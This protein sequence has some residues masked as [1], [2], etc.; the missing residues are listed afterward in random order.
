MQL[1]KICFLLFINVLFAILTVNVGYSQ[2]IDKAAEKLEKYRQEN[3]P[4]ERSYSRIS[5][6]YALQQKFRQHAQYCG[7]E[8][9][10]D[11]RRDYVPS[12]ISKFLG[13]RD[14]RTKVETADIRGGGLMY[15]IFHESELSQ[16]FNV[17][18]YSPT[19]II[20]LNGITDQ[21]ALNPEENF[22]TYIL[23][24]TCGGYLKAALDAGIEPPYAA[25]RAALE[26]DSRRESSILALSGSFVSP[27]KLALDANDDATTEAMMKLWKFYAENPKYVNQ[28]YYLREFEGVLIRHISSAEENRKIEMEG[29]LDLSGLLPARLKTSFGVGA[30][31]QG[32]F[33]GTDWETIIYADY[34]EKGATRAQLFSKLPSPEFIRRYF[35]NVRPA[36]QKSRDFPVMTEGVEHKHFV[37]VEGIPEGMS[38]NFWEIESVKPGVYDG[39][40]TLQAEYFNDSKE[41]SSGC[42]FTITGKPLR[43]NFEGSEATRPSRLPLQYVIRSKNPVGGEYIRF[44]VNEE[45]QTSAHPIASIGAGEFDLTKKE[46]RKFAFQWQFEVDIEDSYNPVDFAETPYIGNLTV[47]RSDKNINVRLAGI[48]HD[49]QRRKFIIT[50][51]TFDT[52]ALEKIDDVNM[53]A[54]NLSLDMYL[55]SKISGSNSVRPL[56]G[57][58]YFPSIK[59]DSP[60]EEPV[61]PQNGNQL[62]PLPDIPPV[63]GNGN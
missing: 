15:Y 42:R 6:G 54:Y 35:E 58:L 48:Q 31:S 52:Y 47:R 38:V 32:V 20:Q 51:E 53:Q 4:P 7:F 28:A 26:T 30:I 27:L 10:K 22:D 24:K 56:R 18:N 41:G 61:L 8:L 11:N 29:G 3:W 23:T 60:K 50:L 59:P 25:L 39:L 1:L 57:V 17:V 36:F 62:Q 63:K 12:D 19:K 37:I 46:D 16:P 40:P 44:Y 49:V 14:L 43:I 55:K 13:K 34:E 9:P 2:K 33:S 45:I 21:Y 5:L